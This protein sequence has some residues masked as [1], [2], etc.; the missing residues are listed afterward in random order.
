MDTDS[1]D[2]ATEFDLCSSEVNQQA[3][4]QSRCF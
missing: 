1:D 3:K 2:E 4:L